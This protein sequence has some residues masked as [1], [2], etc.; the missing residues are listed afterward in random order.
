MRSDKGSKV[1]AVANRGRGLRRPACFAMRLEAFV[2]G[3]VRA[4]GVEG[5]LQRAKL[6][7]SRD[8]QTSTSNDNEHA[9]VPPTD[10]PWLYSSAGGRRLP[11]APC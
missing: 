8:S 9:R 3:D 10:D 11:S 4:N 2:L 7:R 1:H 5:G 6:P